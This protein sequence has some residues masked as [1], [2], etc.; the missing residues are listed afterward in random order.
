MSESKA[1]LN[2]TLKDGDFS[3]TKVR[4][5]VFTALE[6]QEPMTM[7]ELVKRIGSV[8]DRASI[9]R[10]ISLFERLGVVQRLQN[11]WKYTLE[12]S[13]EFHEHHHHIRCL[14]C[15]RL[16]SFSETPSL[17]ATFDKIAAQEDFK[18]VNH[19]LELQGICK[20]C[21]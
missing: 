3:V 4:E 21:Q 14:K 19:Q 7:Q 16:V 20:K 13:D 8:V 15:G 17:E 1:L 9:Y 12:L 18:L 6:D 10:T 2:Q 11:G 5:V